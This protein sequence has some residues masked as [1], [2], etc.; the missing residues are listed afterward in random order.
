MY[1]GRDSTPHVKACL[2]E[3]Q[4]GPSQITARFASP[5]FLLMR[6]LTRPRLM[7]GCAWTLSQTLLWVSVRV[8]SE[9]CW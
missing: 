5:P 1:R 3:H 4:E 9:A 7:L 2:P 8:Q 6:P